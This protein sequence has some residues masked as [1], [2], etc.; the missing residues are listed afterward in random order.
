MRTSLED[1]SYSRPKKT[2][3]LSEIQLPGGTSLR[4]S[5]KEMAPPS[6]E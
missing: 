4:P 2:Q 5:H 3:R 1:D 6:S